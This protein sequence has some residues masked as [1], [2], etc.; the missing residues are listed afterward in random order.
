MPIV[1]CMMQY[2]RS[3]ESTY[4]QEFWGKKAV[5]MIQ[6]LKS[7]PF[8][9]HDEIYQAINKSWVI[10]NS[11]M[12]SNSYIEAVNSV[13]RHHLDTFKKIPVWFCQLFTFFWNNRVFP[14]G[15]RAN[16]SPNNHHESQG[17]N[18]RAWINKI[19]DQFPFEK[20]RSG[21]FGNNDLI[22]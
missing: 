15:K 3:Y 7:Y 6:D 19:M 17:I 4:R 12:K 2:Q 14:R 11:T 21:I 18:S 22:A 1:E 5:R 20:F 8:V 10:I 16:L 13:I 9:D